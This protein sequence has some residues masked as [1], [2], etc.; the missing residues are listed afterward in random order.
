M[1]TARNAV[2]CYG[3]GAGSNDVT[4]NDPIQ[5]CS[6]GAMCRRISYPKLR[7]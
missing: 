7:M 1:L 4:Y 6:S 5:E 3:R 2:S